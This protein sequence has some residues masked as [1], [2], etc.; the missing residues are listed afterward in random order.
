MNRE[1]IITKRDYL[2]CYWSITRGTA[3]KVDAIGL[4]RFIMDRHSPLWSP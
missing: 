2:G 1:Y 3:E 4:I